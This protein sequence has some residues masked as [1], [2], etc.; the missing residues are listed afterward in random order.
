MIETTHSPRIK[1]I[2][3]YHM[4]PGKQDGS[5]ERR[6]V[7]SSKPSRWLGQSIQ[8]CSLLKQV[9]LL[10]LLSQIASQPKI[11]SFSCS[12]LSNLLSPFQYISCIMQGLQCP[13]KTTIIDHIQPQ[14]HHF[15]PMNHTLKQFHRLQPIHTKNMVMHETKD[16]RKL[17]EGSHK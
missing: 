7:H 10:S 16:P 9:E 8:R 5:L 1:T 13:L 11:Y 17:R 14:L 6:K 12:F 4:R 3:M 2:F 15:H